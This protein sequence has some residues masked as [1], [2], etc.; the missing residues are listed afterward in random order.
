MM[1]HAYWLVVVFAITVPAGG[2]LGWLVYLAKMNDAYARGRKDGWRARGV[3]ERERRNGRV[4]EMVE[5]PAP[6]RPG[7]SDITRWY[8]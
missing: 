8:S 7:T 1:V 4:I 5:E 6:S 2:I 3:Y